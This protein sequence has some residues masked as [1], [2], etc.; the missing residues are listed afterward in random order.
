V[1]G[2]GPGGLRLEDAKGNEVRGSFLDDLPHVDVPMPRIVPT[3]T[4][5]DVARD[6]RARADSALRDLCVVMDEAVAKGLQIHF[7]AVRREPPTY[8]HLPVGLRVIKIVAA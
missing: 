1:R 4:D 6:L 3:V 2:D 8:R 5:A 7:D